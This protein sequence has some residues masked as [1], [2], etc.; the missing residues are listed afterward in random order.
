MP[1][2][3]FFMTEDTKEIDEQK[4][5]DDEHVFSNLC[6]KTGGGLSALGGAGFAISLFAASGPVAVILGLVSAALV[7]SGI[8]TLTVG[9]FARTFEG[10]DT[11]KDLASDIQEV[12]S[13]S[14]P[15]C[16]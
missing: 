12:A 3:K 8:F 15:C 9:A 2:Q 10:T 13:S 6:F 14:M 11:A 1:L 7:L 16:N 5:K 4:K